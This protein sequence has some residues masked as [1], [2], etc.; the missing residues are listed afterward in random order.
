MGGIA[1][2]GQAPGRESTGPDPPLPLAGSAVKWA[3]LPLS[4]EM[5][6]ERDISIKTLGNTP[7]IQETEKWQIFLDY[8]LPWPSFFV[9]SMYLFEGENDR[10]TYT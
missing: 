9:R 7:G 5:S 10:Y 1:V 6:M 3:Q 8:Q 4:L 2:R